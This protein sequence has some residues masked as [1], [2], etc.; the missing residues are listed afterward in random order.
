MKRL[1]R[2]SV[3]A[4]Q[5]AMT[6]LGSLVLRAYVVLGLAENR[7]LA[8]TSRTAFV[9]K[10]VVAD[11]L[12]P[13]MYLIELRLVL[14]QA[15]DGSLPPADAAKDVERLAADFDARAKHWTANPPFGLE[16]QLLGEQHQHGQ[17]FVA[18][19][20]A[21]MADLKAGTPD[22]ARQRLAQAHRHYLAHRAG[23]DTTVAAG[24]A[25]AETSMADFH[26]TAQH[27]PL[28]MGLMLVVGLAAMSAM[29]WWISRSITRPLADA[30]RMAQAVAA[31]DLTRRA[32]VQGQDETAQLLS[33]LNYM[34]DQLTATLGQVR[35]SCRLVT[36][37]S[38]QIANGNH[39]L[40]LRTDRHQSDLRNTD[41]A[42]AEVSR[43]VDDN[44]KAADSAHR[45]TE[46][47]SDVANEGVAAMELVGHTIGGIVASSKRVG[48]IVG[49]IEAIAFQTNL[50][51]LNAAVEAARA[52]EQGR[53][54]A[55]VAGEVRLLARRSS[56]AA[57]EIRQLVQD[58]QQAVS[59]G[60]TQ[61]DGAHDA[62][63]R[64]VEQS[65]QMGG[66][67][68]GIWE[69]TFAQGSGINLLRD[70]IKDIVTTADSSAALGTQ[71][72][73]LARTPGRQRG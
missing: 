39:D 12:P 29:A 24:N 14:A 73:Q 60:H 42:I 43:L 37:A 18:E 4:R 13:P 26:S 23:V 30:V 2:L 65:A 45:L 54:F 41:S 33:S 5:L 40:M 8:D 15:L 21:L 19:A 57:R 58:S 66:L 1:S 67:V 36:D 22:K 46:S 31:G 11:I 34:C 71:T 55:V 64:M 62:I 56:T 50:L 25:L 69:T 38:A 52:G 28:R 20:R 35:T 70:A 7:Q 48:D 10:D 59:E 32:P 44:A 49:L 27:A 16:A 47:S 17:A 6:L 72:A 51:A 3:G 61:A 53:G 9:A 68:K 63:R